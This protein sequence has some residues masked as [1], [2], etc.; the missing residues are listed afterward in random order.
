MKMTFLETSSR[1]KTVL[2]LKRG[3]SIEWIG[4]QGARRLHRKHRPCTSQPIL[5]QMVKNNHKYPRDKWN[6]HG[7]VKSG[8]D[9]ESRGLPHISGSSI[10]AARPLNLLNDICST[11]YWGV[12]A[13]SSNHALWRRYSAGAPPQSALITRFLYLNRRGRWVGAMINRSLYTVYTGSLIT[14]RNVDYPLTVWVIMMI[15]FWTVL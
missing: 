2:Q 8:G 9:L 13:G 14:S 1:S 3:N 12:D 10:S 11:V 15:M 7:R 4:I 5:Q 6:F